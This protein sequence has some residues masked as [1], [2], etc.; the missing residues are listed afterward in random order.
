M[1]GK[2][3]SGEGKKDQMVP[4]DHAKALHCIVSAM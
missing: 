1:T 3:G 2:K 4:G